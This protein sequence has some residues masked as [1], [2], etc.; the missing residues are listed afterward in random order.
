[1]SRN[2][3]NRLRPCERVEQV[4]AAAETALQLDLQRVVVRLPAREGDL[5]E[6]VTRDRAAVLQRRILGRGV[7]T[8]LVV[9][10]QRDEL[11]AVVADVGEVEQQVRQQFALHGQVPALH[12]AGTDVARR[13]VDARRQRVEVGRRGQ[14]IWIAGLRRAEAAEEVVPCA[15]SLRSLLRD[16]GADYERAVV[17]KDVLA[18][19]P[20]EVDVADAKAAADGRARRK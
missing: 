4:K 16:A 10:G 18:A 7:R 5:D 2:V 12:V 13:E 14:P 15:Q 11:Y 17:T 20:I 8:G 3:I 6:R 9:I 19:Q 1:M